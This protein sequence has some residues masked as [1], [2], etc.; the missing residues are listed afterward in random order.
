MA[1]TDKKQ[2]ER[3][4][5]RLPPALRER[6]QED[7]KLHS[8][9]M[10]AEILGRLEAAYSYNAMQSEEAEQREYIVLR[11]VERAIERTLA[12][13]I[14]QSSART[15]ISRLQR[16]HAITKALYTLRAIS[17]HELHR[18]TSRIDQLVTDVIDLN[19]TPRAT[20]LCWMIRV[21][22]GRFLTED[23]TD[24]PDLH[25]SGVRFNVFALALELEDFLQKS[26]KREHANSV[27][28]PAVEDP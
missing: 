24:Y 22:L 1:K 27:G 5:L 8:R 28:E 11:Q 10:T 14:D 13:L 23:N 15:P 6:I 4:L 26:S 7:A 19:I 3:L 21:S 2:P 9:T 16:I 17:P 18:H 25:C 20:E 12:G